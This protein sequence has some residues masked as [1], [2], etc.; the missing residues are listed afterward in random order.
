MHRQHAALIAVRSVTHCVLRASDRPATFRSPLAHSSGIALPL[1]AVLLVCSGCYS[2]YQAPAGGFGSPYG[3]PAG[4]MPTQTLQ[5][6]G[7]YTPSPYGQPASPYGTFQPTGPGQPGID[8]TGGNAPFY[9]SGTSGSSVPPYDGG[10]GVPT[11][12]DPNDPSGVNFK[13]P[14]QPDNTAIQSY[15]PIDGQITHVSG[16]SQVG[17]SNAGV[18]IDASTFAADSAKEPFAAASTATAIPAQATQSEP[19][20]PLDV[21]QLEPTP[22]GEF[23]LPQTDFATEIEAAPAPLPFPMEA[24]PLS[25]AATSA[26]AAPFAHDAGFTWLRGVLRFDDASGAWLMIY[27]DN[28]A[29]EDEHGGKLLVADSPLLQQFKP[30]S[31]VLLRGGI[32]QTQSAAAGRAIFRAEVIE[33]LDQSVP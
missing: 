15:R 22:A 20:S 14:L 8:Q 10:G 4:G 32:D 25:P 11:Y 27:S 29:P 26:P 5:P 6:G 16:N 12:S 3:Y 24:T 31:V 13:Q 28:P 18:V 17:R 9:G 7:T 19:V 21:A 23:Q 30:Q 1:L 33:P 2:P